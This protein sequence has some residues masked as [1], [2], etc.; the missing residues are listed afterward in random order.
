MK[1]LHA[2]YFK[3]PIRGVLN[4]VLSEQK[5][6][7]AAGLDFTSKVLC[8]SFGDDYSVI[9]LNYSF[10]KIRAVN[11]FR[12][13]RAYARWLVHQ[14]KEYDAL[15]VRWNSS[16]PFFTNAL[17]RIKKPIFT[18]HHSKE[19]VELELSG[20]LGKL[21]RI[22]DDILFRV[23]SNYVSGLIC[24]TE[25][26]LEFERDRAFAHVPGHVYPNGIYY[27]DSI[28]PNGRIFC[29]AKP[30]II[31]VASAFSA[32]HGLEEVLHS[33]RTSSS[34]FKLHVV[35]DARKYRKNFNED[36]RIVF[37]G[38]L[39]HVEL[40]KMYSS[41][42]IGL[43]SFSIGNSGLTI[44]STLKCRE[45]LASGLPVY[46]GH[47]DVFSPDFPFY[48]VGPPD[49]Q[50]ILDFVQ[51]MQGVDRF[52]VSRAAKPFIDKKLLLQDLCSWIDGVVD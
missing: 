51:S 26:I 1:I 49:I 43:T 8:A 48:R 32:W 45:Y 47:L 9:K 50:K 38:N 19:T 7:N 18:V 42:D 3:E 37:H 23:A 28:V 4:Q 27:D 17:K 13:R 33:A 34:E 10:S 21:R 41:C 31:F 14:S 52:L 46:S 40:T 5:A 25:E 39:N 16:D 35:G 29:G 6:A 36:E 12:A 15:V 11:W 22:V 20:K 24:V 44:A 30:E 2:S